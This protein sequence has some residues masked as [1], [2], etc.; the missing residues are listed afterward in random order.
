VKKIK[1]LNILN[2]QVSDNELIK[3]KKMGKIFTNL[4]NHDIEKKPWPYSG[5]YKLNN[6]YGFGDTV[7]GLMH[8][9]LTDDKFLVTN[10]A[11]DR[12]D[13]A[14][15]VKKL[16]NNLYLQLSWFNYHIDSSQTFCPL[17]AQSSYVVLA[18]PR[19]NIKPQDF[20]LFKINGNQNL[21]INPG[22]WHTNP[23]PI[24]PPPSIFSCLSIQS[25]LH[26]TVDIDLK[27]FFNY[28]LSI[29]LN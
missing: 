9:E 3:T 23:I 25:S 11:I 13:I 5:K 20:L 17:N 4:K 8:S 15:E 7:L 29:K 10:N 12:S 19:E 28:K 27:D 14:G 16:N 24:N 1:M 18:E 26:V 6:T 21:T 22:V 2:L